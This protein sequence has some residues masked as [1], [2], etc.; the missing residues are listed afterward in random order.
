VVDAALDVGADGL[1][2]VNGFA[3]GTGRDEMRSEVSGRAGK[4]VFMIWMDSI[5][6]FSVYL[7]CTPHN[8][9]DRTEKDGRRNTTVKSTD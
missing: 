8:K 1:G 6:D 2:E 7:A 5:W 3:L 9:Y 4:P